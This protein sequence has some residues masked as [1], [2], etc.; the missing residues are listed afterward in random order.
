MGGHRLGCTYGVSNDIT[1]GNKVEAYLKYLS[2][3]A[4]HFPASARGC[5]VVNRPFDRYTT[6]SYT[7]L[8]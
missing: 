1:E 5:L 8:R 4:R 6:Y 2:D 7:D 3:T